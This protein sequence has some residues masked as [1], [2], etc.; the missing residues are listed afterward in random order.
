LLKILSKLTSPDKIKG[1]KLD[2]SKKKNRVN[3][4]RK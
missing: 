1:K 2:Y 4:L 3:N